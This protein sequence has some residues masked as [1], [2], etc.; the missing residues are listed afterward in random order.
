MI[1]TLSY[2]YRHPDPIYFSVEKLF[3]GIGRRIALV[4][5]HEFR[6]EHK[7]LPF[8][9]NWRRLIPNM[10]FAKR[11]QSEI[12]HITGDIHY[13]LLPMGK[14][15]IKVLTVHDCVMLHRHS[16]RNPRYWI[17]KWL[18]YDLPLRKADAVT[19]I[20]ES[21]KMELLRFTKCDPQ[22]IRIIP[23][24]VDARFQPVTREFNK[25]L[26]CILFV[27]STPNKNLERLIRAVEGIKLRLEIIGQLSN[28]QLA[29]L[30]KHNIDYH[31]SSGLS[32]EA[33]MEKY[34]QCDV[35]AFPSTYEGFG[36]PIIE[37]Q[38]IGRPVLTSD[39]APMKDVSGGAACL[40]DPYD[41]ASIRKGLTDLL[42]D[43]GYRERIVAE[44]FVNVA[45]FSLDKVAD[46][47]VALYRELLQKSLN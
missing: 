42:N 20:S 44:G 32:P 37:A 5:G 47:Y 15:K 45:R 33:L 30:K 7:T 26:P 19:V 6:I 36:L 40:V 29:L 8:S 41:P 13:A 27:G 39:I 46:Q 11:H 4:Y 38:A 25:E 16:K 10:G 18:W 17:M 43:G 23:N 28:G 34:I 9:S 21:T 3:T 14:N 12:N 24:F 31:R 22:K 1:Y 2:F 35:L